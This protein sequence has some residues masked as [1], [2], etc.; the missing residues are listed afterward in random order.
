MFANVN[1]TVEAH[2]AP[3]LSRCCTWGVMVSTIVRVLFCVSRH[4]Q[5]LHCNELLRNLTGD[6]VDRASLAA[7]WPVPVPSDGAFPF[8]VQVCF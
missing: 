2:W 8:S 1:T 4:A 6:S 3:A 7:N 5:Y